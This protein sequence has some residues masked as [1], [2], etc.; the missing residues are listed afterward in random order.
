MEISFIHVSDLA[1]GALV[2]YIINKPWYLQS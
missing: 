2:I 1:D